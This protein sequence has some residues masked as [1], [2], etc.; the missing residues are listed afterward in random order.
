VE[1][2]PQTHGASSLSLR[3][4]I[5]L[6]AQPESVFGSPQVMVERGVDETAQQTAELAERIVAA[7]SGK[8]NR[9]AIEAAI[10]GA[11][12]RF[13]RSRIARP[14]RRE[15]LHGCMLG[16][17]DAAFEAKEDTPVA[18]ESFAAL[19]PARRA[20]AK[21]TDTRF[22]QRPLKEAI[23]AFLERKAVTRAEFDA[24]EVAAQRQAFTV[25]NAATT[26]MVRTVKRE[27]IRQVAVGADLADFGKHAAARF[28]AAGWMP[29]NAS[30]VETIF[31]T[32]VVNAY[33]G[34]RVRQMTQPEVL[35]LRPFW[36]ILGVTDGRQRRTHRAAH[37]VVLRANDPF[38]ER[39]A[40]PFGYN[41]R[42]R[43]RSLSL[44]QGAPKVQ[45]GKSI[46][47][48]PDPGFASGLDTLL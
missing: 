29:A 38:W 5:C 4:H 6:A 22:A 45:E 25:A 26:E 8:T 12:K 48:L 37:G 43:I 18:V 13:D 34:G 30:H 31:R 33:S 3:D 44:H 39:A 40:P 14:V 2:Y 10:N 23:A 32:G 24:M 1:A 20:L 17:L 7:V 35:E 41:C 27:L 21:F 9:K 16:A 19:H 46:K 42:C 11:A 28:E 15:L 36:Q 47:G